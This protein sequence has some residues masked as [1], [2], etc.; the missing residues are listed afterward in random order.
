METIELDEIQAWQNQLGNPNLNVRI[1]EGFTSRMKASFLSEL[2]KNN[3][4]AKAF[5]VWNTQV[6]HLYILGEN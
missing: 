3:S 6:I 4:H 5:F 2:L 1:N